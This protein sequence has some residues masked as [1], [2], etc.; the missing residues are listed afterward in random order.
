ME[1]F[2]DTYNFVGPSISARGSQDK[3]DLDLE[4]ETGDLYLVGYCNS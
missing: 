3:L 1:S 2:D 4:T